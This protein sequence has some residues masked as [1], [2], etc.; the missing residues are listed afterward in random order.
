MPFGV[1]C[2]RLAV[3]YFDLTI[4]GAK[5]V[6]SGIRS[7]AGSKY[8]VTQ[9]AVKSGRPEK[10]TIYCNISQVGGVICLK[11]GSWFCSKADILLPEMNSI[12][13]PKEML[14]YVTV[15]FAMT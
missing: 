9:D 6:I 8:L 4:Q 7:G 3:N 12:Q 10:I 1:L 5:V 2:N 14:L 13:E 15:C 11:T